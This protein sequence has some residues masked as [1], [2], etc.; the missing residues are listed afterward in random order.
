MFLLICD[1]T[2]L[3]QEAQYN[4]V[5][6]PVWDLDFWATCWATSMYVEALLKSSCIILT[7]SMY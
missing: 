2:W 6:C 4:T 3:S 1:A 7:T 5:P